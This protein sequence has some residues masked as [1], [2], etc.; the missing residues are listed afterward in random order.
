MNFKIL[1]RGYL[2]KTNLVLLVIIAIIITII[3]VVSRANYRNTESIDLAEGTISYKVPDLNIIAIY[4]DGELTDTMPGVSYKMDNEESF[5][6]TTNKDIK[7][8]VTL[9]IDSEGNLVIGNLKK[10]VNVIYIL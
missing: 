2:K 6:Y 4:L 10:G 9:S 7:E 5:C 3:L 1:N 8:D